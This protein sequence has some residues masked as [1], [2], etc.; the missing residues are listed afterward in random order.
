MYFLINYAIFFSEK[1]LDELE[2][3]DDQKTIIEN[4]IMDIHKFLDKLR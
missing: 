2:A 1:L 3:L 4:R